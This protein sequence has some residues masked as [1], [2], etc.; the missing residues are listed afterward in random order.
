MKS[1][2]VFAFLLCISAGYGL[3]CYKCQT[4]KDWDDCDKIKTEETCASGFDRCGKAHVEGKSGETS[5]SLYVKGC[6][7][8]SQCDPDTSPL[9]KSS[10]PLDKFCKC[11]LNCCTDDLCN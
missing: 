7:T 4:T 10:D 5:V 1:L 9:C 3:K 8:S 11:N 6:A 2:F